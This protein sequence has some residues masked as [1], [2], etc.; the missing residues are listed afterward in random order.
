MVSK[1]LSSGEYFSIGFQDVNL[2]HFYW[3]IF[4]QFSKIF[5]SVTFDFSLRFYNFTLVYFSSFT[6]LSIFPDI[7]WYPFVLYYGYMILTWLCLT[8]YE[9]SIFHESSPFRVGYLQ[10]CTTVCLALVYRCMHESACL[11]VFM[12][13]A[14]HVHVMYA[15]VSVEG[16]YL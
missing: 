16:I 11:R 13:M 5:I 3:N 9:S 6:S 7:S 8:Q 15:C 14:L 1:L 12:Y 10:W 4:P 2:L